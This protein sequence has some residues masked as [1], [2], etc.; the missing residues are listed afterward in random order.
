MLLEG[1]VWSICFRGQTALVRDARGLQMLARLVA[2]PEQDI[3]VLDLSGAC[4]PGIAGDDAGPVLDDKARQEYRRRVHE[5]EEELE[6]A[7]ELGDQGRIEALQEELD[8][9]AR[10]LSRA[11]GLG[12]RRRPSGAAAE[13]ARV[14]VRRRIK[15]AISRIGEQ[16]PDAGRYLDNTVKT[17]SYC[18]YAPL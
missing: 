2:H 17:G 18:R 1:D 16:L 10:E 4:A 12:G 9:I 5:L 6:E 3:H 8:F 15:D 13:R 11:F 14:N 7:T